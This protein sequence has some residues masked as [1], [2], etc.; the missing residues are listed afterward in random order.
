MIRSKKKQN[1][2]RLAMLK[3]YFGINM[4]RYRTDYFH[5]V[6]N[7]EYPKMSKMFFSKMAFKSL[8]SRR[9]ILN[10]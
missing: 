9:L 5:R 3:G 10:K 8:K 2:Y 6:I 7:G 1:E 4:D